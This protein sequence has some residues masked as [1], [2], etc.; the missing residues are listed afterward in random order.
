MNFSSCQ[1]C[2]GN[3]TIIIQRTIQVPKSTTLLHIIE[4][5]LILL[6]AVALLFANATK[7]VDLDDFQFLGTITMSVFFFIL[8]GNML[9]LVV[10]AQLYHNLRTFRTETHY[11][12]LCKDCGSIREINI[13]PPENK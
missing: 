3:N 13:L 6:F 8:A 11:Y 4:A 1:N 12:I 7:D 9:S 5:I 10:F 2:K